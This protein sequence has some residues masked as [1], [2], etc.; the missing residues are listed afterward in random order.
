MT[1]EFKRQA[2]GAMP[3][4]P[5][6]A[7][8]VEDPLADESAEAARGEIDALTRARARA[9]REQDAERRLEELKRRMGK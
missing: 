3:P 6:P 2:M 1:A 7:G 9:D 5:S 4:P 8:A